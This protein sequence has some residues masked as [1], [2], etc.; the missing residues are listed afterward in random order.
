MLSPPHVPATTRHRNP[1]T[2][3]QRPAADEFA[4]YY[5][6][7]IDQVADG[8]VEAVLEE[9]GAETLALLRSLAE[10]DGGRAYAE[11]KWTIK[12]VIGHVAD[13]ERI[14]SY[15]LMRAARGDETPLPSFDENAFAAAG[16]FGDRT[17]ASLADEL[18]AVRAATLALVRGLPEGAW[19]RRGVASGY[20][21][22]VRAAAYMIAGHEAHHVNL[23]RERYLAAA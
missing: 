5:G 16:R 14:F 21:F 17:L 19:D 12:E 3:N 4:P 15:R 20:G 2:M 11:G 13:T 8:D 7:Y 18:A 10:E 9:Q 22:S 23:L 1:E 6:R